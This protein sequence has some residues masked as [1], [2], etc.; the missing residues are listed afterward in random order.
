MQDKAA[1]DAQN[2]AA[3]VSRQMGEG[4]SKC[5]EGTR[6]T[7]PSG[8]AAQELCSALMQGVCGGGATSPSCNIV[9]DL[10]LGYMFN[11]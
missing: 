5:G 1:R 3:H 11:H 2:S 4:G 7:R 8:K 10:E 6:L 9:C